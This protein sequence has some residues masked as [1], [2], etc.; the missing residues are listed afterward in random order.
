MWLRRGRQGERRGK[1]ETCDRMGQDD[2]RGEQVN[3]DE[4]RAM[5]NM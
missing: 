4:Q 2:E 1:E 5:R 3:D